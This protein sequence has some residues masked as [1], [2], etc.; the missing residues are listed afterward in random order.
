M[1]NGGFTIWL[2]GLPGAGKSTISRLVADELERR[3]VL[4][5][6]LDGDV[7]RTHLS[8]GLGYSR[9]DRETN[10]GRIGWVASRLARAGA[11]VVVAAIA[12]FADT[13]ARAR[14]MTEEHATFLEVH[15]NASVEACGERDPK[16]L[17]AK[18]AAG[19]IADFTGVSAPYEAPEDPDLRVDT[20]TEDPAASAAR[21]I[22]L[23]ESR[24]LI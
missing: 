20:E 23:L 5:E 13:R 1:Q 6:L 2:T 8:Q 19:E 16:G 17:Y 4:V 7:V 14:A 3:G 11:G 22:A 12:P 15:V 24:D 9:E 10:I 21:V 18:A